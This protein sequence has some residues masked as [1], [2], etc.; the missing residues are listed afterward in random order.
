M[1]NERT[2]S[3]TAADDLAG[4]DLTRQPQ[5]I[6]PAL[7][8]EWSLPEVKDSKYGRGQV[9][10]IGGAAQTP[11]AAM[12]TGLAA[13]RVGAGHLTLA[14][15]ESAAVAVA[16]AVPEAGVVGLPENG[17]GSVRGG[18]LSAVADR[19]GSTDV[20]VVG[21]GLDDA[22]ETAAL[23]SNLVPLLGEHT[24]VVLD[25]YALGALPDVPELWPGFA[26]RVILTP[27]DSEAERLLGR[28]P[29]ELE[30]DLDDVADR[31][32]ALVSCQNTITDGEGG[33]WRVATGHGGLATSGSGDVLAGAV[34]GVLAR[35]ATRAQAACWATHLHAA[36]GDRLAVRVGAVG[37]LASELLV[38]LPQLL[39]ELSG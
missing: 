21:P 20:V 25:A 26:G 6:T 10:V 29:K 27:N 32:G 22:E 24:Q 38:E 33:R 14:V 36:A 30:D 5:V 18:D 13:L 34:A 4:R 19:L 2:T 17:R 11:G 31:Y 7:L 16:V 39:T 8:R 35:G 3:D 1:A 23:L 28:E 9:L 12:L 15:A 37:F